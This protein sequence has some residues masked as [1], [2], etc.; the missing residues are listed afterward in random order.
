MCGNLS[1]S[2]RQKKEKSQ[3]D[4]HK[5]NRQCLVV[6]INIVMRK[7]KGTVTSPPSKDIA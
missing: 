1:R 7:P 3:A 5:C 4:V 6:K 2:G